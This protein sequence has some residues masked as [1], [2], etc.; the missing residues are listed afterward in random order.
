[1]QQRGQTQRPQKLKVTVFRYD[2]CLSLWHVSIEF[3]FYIFYFEYLF[4][5]ILPFS[6]FSGC[7]DVGMC[8]DNICNT[9][10]TLPRI[11]RIQ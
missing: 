6:I 2:K 11:S 5:L 3:Y 1:M 8:G 4:D 7:Q 10:D 9:L